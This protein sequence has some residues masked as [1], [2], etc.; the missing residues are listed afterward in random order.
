MKCI[1]CLLSLNPDREL[2]RSQ[3]CLKKSKDNAKKLSSKS[4]P[5]SLTA[6][7]AGHLCLLIV[8]VGEATGFADGVLFDSSQLSSWK[9]ESTKLAG[10]FTPTEAFSRNDH[11]IASSAVLGLIYASPGNSFCASW[12]VGEGASLIESRRC[13]RTIIRV[14]D[15]F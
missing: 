12:Y 4:S 8:S 15:G 5:G 7:F 10:V 9:P 11:S 3:M 2:I 13:F 14:S 6:I 1:S